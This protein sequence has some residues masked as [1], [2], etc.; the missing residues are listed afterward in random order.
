MESQESTHVEN[1]AVTNSKKESVSQKRV[2]V[3]KAKATNLPRK[4][5]RR[6][7][8]KGEAQQMETDEVVNTAVFHEDNKVIIMSTEDMNSKFMSGDEHHENS[9]ASHQ[10]VNDNEN[11]VVASDS[12]EEESEDQDDEK[13]ESNSLNAELKDSSENYVKSGKHESRRTTMDSSGEYE[14]EVTQ[15]TTSKGYGGA[16]PKERHYK[17]T[18]KRKRTYDDRSNEREERIINKAVEKLQQLM[19]SSQYMRDNGD[20]RSDRR[21]RERSPSREHRGRDSRGIRQERFQDRGEILFNLHRKIDDLAK[22]ERS[23]TMVYR[24]VIQPEYIV[25]EVK[26]KSTSS[27]DNVDT[28][29]ELINADVLGYN[30]NEEDI[31]GITET[32]GRRDRGLHRRGSEPTLP[33]PPPRDRSRLEQ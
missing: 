11:A 4:L 5:G 3:Q 24:D 17:K 2:K 28:S 30:N 33:P 10:E 19:T 32:D 13:S 27:E 23:E 9:Q 21:N 20:G 25:M 16:R 15:P 6:K 31:Y 1:M 7:G 26:R 29:N 22:L 8:K 18:V 12:D 14:V